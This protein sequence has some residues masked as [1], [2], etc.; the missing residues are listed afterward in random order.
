MRDLK[1]KLEVRD[2]HTNGKKK[3]LQERLRKLME[4]NGED[5]ENHV[6]EVDDDITE[7]KD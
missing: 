3:Y 2:Q 4:E 5:L 1:R 6:F 7:L